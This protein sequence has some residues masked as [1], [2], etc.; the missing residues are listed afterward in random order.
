MTERDDIFHFRNFV[1]LKIQ[2][3]LMWPSILTKHNM[4]DVD[5]VSV[6]QY[7]TNEVLY[8][9]CRRLACKSWPFHTVSQI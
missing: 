9:A 4:L 7:V 8:F 6:M 5:I 1:K 2:R 3:I